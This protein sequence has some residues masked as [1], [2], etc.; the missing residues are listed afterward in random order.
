MAPPL[1]SVQVI[2]LLFAAG[3][4]SGVLSGLLGLGG[5]SVYIPVLLWIFQPLYLRHQ[6]LNGAVLANAF[7]VVV[8]VSLVSSVAHHRQSSI[9]YAKVPPLAMG[10]AM[11]AVAGFVLSQQLGLLAFM[12]VLFGAY[13]LVLAGVSWFQPL[14]G[15]SGYGSNARFLGVGFLSGAL[16]GFVGFNGN[17]VSIPLLR[18][19]G[20]SLRHSMATGN[21]AGL[22]VS[23][24]LLYLVVSKIGLP[25]ISPPV[26]AALAL[27]GC[28]GS[29]LGARINSRITQSRLNLGFSLAC[30]GAGLTIIAMTVQ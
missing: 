3:C 30:I 9:Q 23:M 21:L 24:V 12:D 1:F 25:Q 27:G 26:C 14:N 13:L 16:G 19:C 2:G 7:F 22:V 18:K 4:F 17:T 15:A 29:P 11:G 5:M 28:L 10:A 8:L 6:D 20:L